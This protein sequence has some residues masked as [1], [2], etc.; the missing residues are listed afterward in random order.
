MPPIA[1]ERRVPRGGS[2]PFVLSIFASA[3]LIFQVQPMVGKHILP[4]FG[5]APGVWSLC[6][7]FYQT[8]LFL[9]YAYAHLLIRRVAP[10]RQP[11]VHALLLLATLAVLPVLP[12]ASWKPAGDDSPSLRILGMLAA[13]VGPPFLLLAA[14]GPLVQAWFARA[15]P[16]RSPYPLYAVS[17]A[18]SL[19][20]LLSYPVAIEPSL[21]LSVQSR[22]WSGAFT[23]CGLTVLYCAWR[24]TRT[25][26]N[27]ADTTAD[28]AAGTASTSAGIHTPRA[29]DA[30]LWAALPCCAVILLM[31]L[32]NELC[33]DIASVP[34]LWII[35]LSIYLLTFIL[36]FASARFYR[37]GLFALLSA[38][39]L[40]LLLQ[41]QHW[42]LTPDSETSSDVSVLWQIARYSLLLFAC[43]SLVHGELYRLR[44]HPQRLTAYYLCIAGGGAVGGL[45]VGV[46]AP[47]VFSDYYELGAGI[48]ACWA[49]L[50][51]CVWRDPASALHGGRPRAA[52]ALLGA[53][54][55][56]CIAALSVPERDPDAEVL[57]QRRNFFGVLRVFERNRDHV[58]RHY[59]V[60]RSGTTK[61]G[62]QYRTAALRSQPTT[63]YGHATGAGFTLRQRGPGERTR[64]GL[65]GLGI[66]TLSAYGR[67]GDRF[68]YYEIDPDVIG[69]ASDEQYFSY[70]ADSRATT[71]IMLGDARLSLEAELRDGTPQGFDIL[72][73]DAFTSDAI[74][75]H[76]LTAEAFALYDRH[77]ADA[78]I[79]LV[80]VSNRH[81]DLSP[82]LFGHAARL[83]MRAVEIVNGVLRPQRSTRSHWVVLSRDA[84]YIGDLLA[85]V[86]AQHK[87]LGLT[88]GA[89]GVRRPGADSA[90]GYPIWTDDY[91][92]L[93]SLFRS[94]GAD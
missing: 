22:V 58:M 92:N 55:L 24:A 45:F 9:G 48:A 35:P 34:F 2:A 71:E 79:I 87:E 4:W 25:A 70:L 57:A 6:L 29:G 46:A 93:F 94:N 18:G 36:C 26:H 77:L 60:L 52:W 88:R 69:I 73:L 27:A 84:S 89:V 23:A 62:I 28:R 50:A 47:V 75:V 1:A 83:D 54:G 3:F 56:A 64:V 72:V 16:A 13:N 41:A 49:L 82:L 90:G 63:Y 20:A 38:A 8:A 12:E 39:A 80:H 43:C 44:P 10:A 74:P 59:R 51:F 40:L 53:L 32:T 85:F 31:G 67:E 11:I 61:H 91:S 42:T 30:L 81:L 66:G 76:L 14:T 19:L 7:A 21:A 5:G 86:R 65:I 15:F 78:G 37:R 17:N 68:R 33:L